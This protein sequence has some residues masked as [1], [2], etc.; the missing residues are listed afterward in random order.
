MKIIESGNHAFTR[1]DLAVVIATLSLLA[2]LFVRAQE[3][4]D[5]RTRSERIQ[6]VNQ[7]KQ[8]GLAFRIWANDNADKFPMQVKAEKGGSLEAIASGEAF[9][10]FTV[11][12]N[13]LN[14]TK[15]LVCPADD[16]ERAGSFAEFGNTNLSYFVGLDANEA[17]PQIILSGDRNV[18]NGLPR[19]RGVLGLEPDR[20]TGWTAEMHVE[21]GNI[22]LCDGSAQQVTTDFLRRQVA[23]GLKSTAPKPQ[24]WQFPE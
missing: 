9:R 4:A 3:E 20:P 19:P 12:S 14:R 6:C 8:I 11:M 5:A 21:K 23:E 24:R 16:R 10:H 22:G 13:E 15:I 2:V 1:I 18:T 17:K 7:L